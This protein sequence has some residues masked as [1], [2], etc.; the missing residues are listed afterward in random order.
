MLCAQVLKM[1]FCVTVALAMLAGMGMGGKAAFGGDTVHGAQADW[2]QW[3]GPNRNSVAPNSPKLL[4]VWSKDG[5]S[6]AWQ[7]PMFHSTPEDGGMGSPV[8]GEGKFV[9]FFNFHRRIPNDP[10]GVRV[11]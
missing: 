10:A 3:R 5:P 2:P 4:D 7:Y 8:V 9:A 6:L 11:W 1:R